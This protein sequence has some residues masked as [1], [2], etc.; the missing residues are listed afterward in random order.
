MSESSAQRT[1]HL[2]EIH[3]QH[4]QRRQ[5]A[6]ESFGGGHADFRS[7]VGEIVPAASRVTIEPTT[8]QMASVWEPFCLASRCAASVSAVSPDW[9]MTR[10]AFSGR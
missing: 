8:L 9:E 2:A 6:G 1:A 10:S 7:G 3:R 4:H 5:L